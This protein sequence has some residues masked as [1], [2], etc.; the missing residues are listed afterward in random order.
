[1]S[2]V[3]NLMGHSSI[4]MTA[5]NYYHLLGDEKRRTIAKLPR[6]EQAARYF[7]LTWDAV[8]QTASSPK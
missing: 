1:M 7:R 3:S 6:L 4:Q 5:N 2:A 8:E